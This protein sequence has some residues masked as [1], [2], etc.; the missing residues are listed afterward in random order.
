MK[1]RVTM[2]AAVLAALV[3]GAQA[4]EVVKTDKLSMNIYGRGQMYGVGQV[5]QDPHRDDIRVYLFMKQARL[6]VVGNYEDLRYEAQMAF[7]GENANGSNTDL[8][9]LDFVADIPLKL[10]GTPLSPLD[11]TIFKIGQFRAPFS[12]EG[13]TD[14]GYMDFGERS[15]ATMP[16]YQ[17]RDYGIALHGYP[18]NFAWTAGV[19]SAGG[20]DVPQRYLPE[21]LGWPEV[22]ARF[23]YNDGIDDDIYHV[24]GRSGDWELKAPK[25]GKAFF[26]NGLF[27]QDSKIGHGTILSVKTIDKNLMVN[28]NFNPFIS[29]GPNNGAASAGAWE[30]ERGTLWAVGG[31]AVL[32]KKLSEDSQAELELEGNW[33]GYDNRFGALHGAS[34]RVQGGYRKG[35]FGINARYAALMMDKD[36]AYRPSTPAPGR[37]RFNP[38]LGSTIHE[39]TPSMTWHFKG[40]NMKLVAD[41]PMY[42]NMPVFIENRIGS[43]VFA[44][45]PD[46]VT[47]I[48]SASNAVK[49]RSVIEGRMLFQFAF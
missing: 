19:F 4:M 8:G 12:R 33:T 17:G 45:Q 37:T 16:V 38:Q 13:L 18:G 22:I 30:T 43:Y 7:G 47:Y 20:R 32:R 29:M 23:G 3:S 26:V 36:M 28:T 25:S 5:V 27:M 46:Q 40:H 41:L 24:R 10:E 44:S 1:V 14:R 42:F 34:G 49:R 2:V 6:G 35:R 48:S 9:L 15:I 39:I 11:G 31:D 21:G